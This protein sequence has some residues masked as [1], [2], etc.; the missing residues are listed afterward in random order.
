MSTAERIPKKKKKKRPKDGSMSLVEHIQELRRRLI[1]SLI[2]LGVGT[3]IGF[4]WYQNSMFGLPT[5]GEILRGPYCSLPPEARASFSPDGSCKLLATAPFEMFMLRLKVGALAGAVFASPVWLAQLWGFITPGLLKNERRWTFSFVS[6][7]VVLFVSGAMLAYFVLAY[8]L[9]FLLTIGMDSQT[10]ALNGAQYFDLILALL[11][12]FGVSFEV[13]LIIAMLNI[14]GLVSYEQLRTKR[15]LIIMLLA[16]FAAFMT[17]GQDPYSMV[18]LGA[19]LVLLV[20]IAIQFARINDKRRKRHRPDWL[21][22]DD[23]AS[24][25]ISAATSIH[26]SSGIDATSTID[27]PAPIRTAHDP[28]APTTQG[29]ELRGNLAERG[30]SDF[31]DVL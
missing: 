21:D 6:I 22:V 15:R 30:G 5:L 14:M 7:A 3:I 16:V 31:D 23:D 25:P 27:A 18:A 17:P 26:P 12:I 10:T 1:I 13:P 19:A 8:G 20:E 2:S 11:V 9:E 28:V 24:T 29:A 4:W